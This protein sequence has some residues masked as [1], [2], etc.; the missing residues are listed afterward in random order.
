[1]VCALFAALFRRWPMPSQADQGLG[2]QLDHPGICALNQSPGGGQLEGAKAD[3]GARHAAHHRAWLQLGVAVVELRGVGAGWGRT[4]CRATSGHQGLLGQHRRCVGCGMQAA[5]SHG[6]AT[7]ERTMCCLG[8]HASAAAAHAM[9]CHALPS[10][11]M[12]RPCHASFSSLPQSMPAQHGVPCC[13]HHVT[14][15]L[16]MGM[17]QVQHQW[18]LLKSKSARFKKAVQ[19]FQLNTAACPAQTH[20]PAATSNAHALQG[21]AQQHT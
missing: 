13:T 11:A 19:A 21:P 7:L 1:M 12:P 3:E 6:R 10:H 2:T 17:E 5:P 8:L 9:P 4:Q 16:R 18:P 15:H 14:V 20:R